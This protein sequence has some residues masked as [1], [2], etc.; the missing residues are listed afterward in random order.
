MSDIVLGLLGTFAYLI[1]LNFVQ[2]L[3]EVRIK[4][5]FYYTDEEIESHK[6]EVT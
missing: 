3:I 4:D 6:S 5:Y 2:Q 1:L